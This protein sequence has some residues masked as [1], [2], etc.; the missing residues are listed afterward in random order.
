MRLWVRLRA[1]L[2][3]I[4]VASC[5]VKLD[6]WPRQAAGYKDAVKVADLQ[7]KGITESSGIAASR[8][9]PGVYW[10][11]N[12]SGDGANLY[13]T[14]RKG[15]ALA[16]FT[17]TGATAVDWE[18]M[19]AAGTGEEA[20]LYIGDIGDNGRNRDDTCVYRVYEPEVD[21][22]LTGHAGK[23]MLA[24]KLPFRYP[25]GHHDAETLMV[26]PV[27]QD[28]FIVTKEESGVSGVYKFPT[29]LTR[30]RTVTLE[31]V[32]SVRFTNPLRLRGNNVGKLATAGDI[33]PDG[34]R[35]VIR[36][37]T[38]AFEWTASPEQSIGSAL[39]AKA[40]AVAVPWLG[41][42]EA[43]CY[44]HDGKSLLTTSEGRP[45]PLWELKAK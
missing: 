11:H 40:R 30:N 24:E 22:A 27:S 28:V 35:I 26:H 12:D 39:A 23:T 44:S 29:P 5:G 4:A 1:L 42:Y 9:T 16:S 8:R 21:V 10:V 14:D 41:Q 20:R 15:R 33:S 32:G 17:L 7:E 38:D 13:A 25:D 37:Y 19:A 6:A 43:I 2:V 18:D 36:T 31:K 34:L 45:C 3:F